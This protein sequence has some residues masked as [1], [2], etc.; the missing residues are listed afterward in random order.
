MPIHDWTR[1]K[2]GTFHD[3]HLA[4]IAEMRKAFYP[5]YDIPWV[6]PS[7]VFLMAAVTLAL[8]LV[9]LHRWVLDALDD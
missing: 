1:V 2:A 8:G 7:Y 4:W 3:F 5:T 6:Y 9:G